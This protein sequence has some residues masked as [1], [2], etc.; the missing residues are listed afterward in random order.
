MIDLS[1]YGRS[2]LGLKWLWLRHAFAFHWAHKPLCHRFRRDVLRIGPLH[3][4]RSCTLAYLG[5]GGGVLLCA[6]WWKPL[7]GSAATLFLTLAT[8]T[9]LLSFPTWYRHWP[10]SLR[11]VLRLAMGTTIALCV[12]LLLTGQI[13]VGLA[14]GAVLAVFWKAYM[15][16]RRPRRLN[17]CSGCPELRSDAICSGFTFQAEQV[18]RYEEAA[19]ERIIGS[20]Y[21]PHAVRERQKEGSDAEVLRRIWSAAA[22]FGC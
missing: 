22:G 7:E 14:G 20:G 1:H 17:A 2:R 15:V 16:L 10:R 9:L 12:Y 5:F 21:L 4:C 18:R 11:D 13:L 8:P 19:T 3:V 6:L